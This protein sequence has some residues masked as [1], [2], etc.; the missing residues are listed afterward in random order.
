MNILEHHGFEVEQGGGGCQLLSF[1]LPNGVFIW[2]TCTD[3]G[4]LPEPDDFMVCTY[5][6]E[7]DDVIFEASSREDPCTLEEAVKQALLAAYKWEENW[8]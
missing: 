7:M 8:T 6:G 1:Y 3:G 5:A 2:A 4:G